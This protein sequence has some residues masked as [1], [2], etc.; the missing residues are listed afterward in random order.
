MY[1][2]VDQDETLRMIM[3]FVCSY[4][5]REPYY[6]NT[7]KELR[8]NL[9]KIRGLSNEMLTIAGNLIFLNNFDHLQTKSIHCTIK[10]FILTR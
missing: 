4:T 2:G 7:I 6:E 8:K 9:R 5:T 1:F 3:Y 10:V